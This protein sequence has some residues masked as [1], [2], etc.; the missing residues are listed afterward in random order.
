VATPK[1]KIDRPK[2]KKERPKPSPPVPS[3]KRKI[4]D[5][6]AIIISSSEDRFVQLPPR[7]ATR[8]NKGALARP[9]RSTDAPTTEKRSRS[10]IERRRAT[11]ELASDVLEYPGQWLR[12]PNT[13]LGDRK[14]IDLI[15]TDEEEKV[16]NLLNAVDQGLF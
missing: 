14:P 15:D 10:A 11:L 13:S 7:T 16:Y 2:L 8:S 3:L 1:F 6:E 4:R 9:P 12:T 5:G